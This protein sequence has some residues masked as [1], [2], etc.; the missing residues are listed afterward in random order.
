MRE[1][2]LSQIRTY[3][4]IRKIIKNL[5]GR[6]VEQSSTLGIVLRLRFSRFAGQSKIDKFDLGQVI[7]VHNNNIFWLQISMDHIHLIMEVLNTGQDALHHLTALQLSQL[8]ASLILS[9]CFETQLHLHYK[10]IRKRL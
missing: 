4:S 10:I 1:V 3:F 8:D 6:R 7:I 2:I 5:L 9:E